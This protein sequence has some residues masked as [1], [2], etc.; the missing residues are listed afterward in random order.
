M[1]RLQRALEGVQLDLREVKEHA[2]FVQ[3]HWKGLAEQLQRPEPAPNIRPP[4]D[5]R[6]R[7]GTPPSEGME[8]YVSALYDN[9]GS[10]ADDVSRH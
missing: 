8:S 9:L 3:L 4:G 2:D 5:A 10:E 1:C 6:S 7:E